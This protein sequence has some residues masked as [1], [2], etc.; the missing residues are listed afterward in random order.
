MIKA[1]DSLR[2]V[3]TTTF[4]FSARVFTM[5]RIWLWLIPYF[6]ICSL[7]QNLG[8]PDNGIASTMPLSAAC[9]QLDPDIISQEDMTMSSS[10][11]NINKFH[12]GQSDVGVNV[13]VFISRDAS[14]QKIPGNIKYDAQYIGYDISQTA[15]VLMLPST[16]FHGCVLKVSRDYKVEPWVSMDSDRNYLCTNIPCCVVSEAADVMANT[17]RRNPQVIHT[18]FNNEGDSASA[19]ASTVPFGIDSTAV[20]QTPNSVHETKNWSDSDSVAER[21]PRVR[22]PATL[23]K[24]LGDDRFH[25]DKKRGRKHV[26]D[27]CCELITFHSQARPFDGQYLAILPGETSTERKKIMYEQGDHDFTWVCTQCLFESSDHADLEEFRQ[28]L[29]NDCVQYR[30]TRT[31]PNTFTLA[32]K[33]DAKTMNYCHLDH[34]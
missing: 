16:K 27:N 3:Y 9:R 15:F 2:F 23:H 20:S 7:L 25:K 11:E 30:Q 8:M 19:S 6:N 28:E 12:D 14:K 18:T 13:I 4:F 21:A 32:L 5:H 29:G 17:E 33:K 34:F 31:Q 26:C 10:V 24:E 22:K 1:A